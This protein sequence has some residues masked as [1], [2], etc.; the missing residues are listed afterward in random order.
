VQ[1]DGIGTLVRQPDEQIVFKDTVT[2]LTDEF[3]GLK[4]LSL[5]PIKRMSAPSTNENSNYQLPISENQEP[6]RTLKLRKK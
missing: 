6:K 3:N 5:K 4:A 1:L 2:Q